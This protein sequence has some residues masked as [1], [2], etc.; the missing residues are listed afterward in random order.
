MHK[1]TCQ[2]IHLTFNAFA[3]LSLVCAAHLTKYSHIWQAGKAERYVLDIRN[4]G[5]GSFPAG[6]QVC[7]AHAL[8]CDYRRTNCVISE[9]CCKYFRDNIEF[10]SVKKAL[11]DLASLRVCIVG[12]CCF[13]YWCAVREPCAFHDI[14]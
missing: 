2:G 5:G 12:L 8:G 4:N 1:P 9:A 10:W 6:V 14:G 13:R 3:S 11:A 7:D